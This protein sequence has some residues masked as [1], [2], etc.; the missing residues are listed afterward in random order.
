MRRKAWLLLAIVPVALVAYL[1]MRSPAPA[2]VSAGEATKPAKPTV[3][4]MAE[5]RALVAR[6]KAQADLAAS[7][8]S[9]VPRVPPMPMVGPMEGPV[10]PGGQVDEHKAAAAV[11]KLRDRMDLERNDGGLRLPKVGAIMEDSG[12]PLALIGDSLV[13]EGDTV[14]GYRVKKIQTDSV[15][16]EKDGQTWVRK[17]N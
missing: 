7:A 14:Q 13:S 10:G 17:V 11:Q 12:R 5:A 16:F 15:E 6:V 1:L 2:P 3:D 9:I 4:E 8:K